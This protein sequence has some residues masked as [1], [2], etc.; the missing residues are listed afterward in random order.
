MTS[1]MLLGHWLLVNPRLPRWALQRLAL[2]AGAGLALDLA[3]V[4]ALGAFGAGDSVM[5]GALVA[6]ASMTAL[7]VAA[8]WFSL[9]EQGC[10]GAMAAT[11]L[12][13]LGVLTTY[14]VVVFDRLLV[15]GL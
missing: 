15:A 3:V 9:K 2:A 12:F 1:E 10:S 14:G 7:L 11:G 8:A 13:C 6:L 4:A 5:I